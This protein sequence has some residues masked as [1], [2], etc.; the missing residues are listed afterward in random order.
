MKFQTLP[1]NETI[2]KK[3]YAHADISE[4]KDSRLKDQNKNEFYLNLPAMKTNV[5]IIF[6]S[7]QN[8]IS[9]RVSCKHPV[10]LE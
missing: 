8:E 1:Q 6:F 4:N 9:F 10:N 7:R 2:R 3:T 5:N